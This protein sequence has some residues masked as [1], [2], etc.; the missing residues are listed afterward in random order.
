MG[1]QPVGQDLEQLAIRIDTRSQAFRAVIA[2]GSARI[3]TRP[4]ETDDPNRWEVLDEAQVAQPAAEQVTDVEFWHADQ[5]LW[6][7]VGGKK[8][9]HA[10]YDWGPI[11]RFELSTGQ[12]LDAQAPIVPAPSAYRS[13]RPS[14]ALTGPVKLHRLALD[15]DLYYQTTRGDSQL[16]V[17]GSHP[18]LD[19]AVLEPGQFFVFGDNSA[20]SQ[21][22]RLLGEPSPWVSPLGAPAGIVP[23]ELMMGRAFFVYF[24]AVERRGALPIPGFGRLRF[25]W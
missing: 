15:R 4:I 22:S 1:V 19:L 10:T 21:D 14:V 7:F 25:I 12:P 2:G 17:R 18:S 8:V 16:P 6:L 11:E 5:A 3:E 24:P 13:A 20:S 9:A 23:E